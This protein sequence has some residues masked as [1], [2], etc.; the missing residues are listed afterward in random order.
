MVTPF[1]TDY[2]I[3]VQTNGKYSEK[4]FNH[5]VGFSKR[6]RYYSVNTLCFAKCFEVL[7]YNSMEF[8]ELISTSMRNVGHGAVVNIKSFVRKEHFSVFFC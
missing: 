6:E 2:Y 8:M 7:D 1:V 4:S 5:A 3:I